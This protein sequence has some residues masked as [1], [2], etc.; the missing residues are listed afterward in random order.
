MSKIRK[1]FV[2]KNCSY[3]TSSWLGQC[4][5]CQEWNSFEENLISS[6][7]AS[8]SMT[9]KSR[10][11][12]NYELT[13]LSKTKSTKVDRISSNMPEVDRVLGGGFVPGQV[14]L[15][16]GEPGIGKS[17][18]LLEISKMLQ[19]NVLYV[20]AEESTQQ[21]K[22]RAERLGYKG[23][24][25]FVVQETNA[26]SV[27]D[28]IES[29]VEKDDIN[30]VIIDSIQ[31][32]S[33]DGLSG[34]AGSVGQLR[35][36]AQLFTQVA[37]RIHVPF[38]LVGHVTKEGEVAGPKVLEHIVDTVLILEGDTQNIF[39]ILKTSKNRFG[40]VSEV[41]VFEMKNEG[42][43]QVENPSQV[44]LENYKNRPGSCIT[45]TME[46]FRPILFEIQALTVKTSYGYPVRRTSGFSAN[47][48]QV[49]LAILERRCGVPV[50]SY[51]VYLNVVGGFNIS[52]YAADLAVC[53]SVA[54]SIKDIALKDGICAF[55]ECG[56]GGELRKIS[57]IEKRIKEAKKL[58]FSRVVSSDTVSSLPD[59]IKKSLSP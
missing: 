10:P 30:L 7:N 33:A 41:G 39:R 6:T 44:F 3:E 40:A 54:S 14:I 34:M 36:C 18:I 27:C 32:F 35:N 58:G 17:T 47:R 49:L 25:M 56:L 37:K 43:V 55:G 38:V 8:G 22:I 19:K 2:C 26:Q 52:E 29:N 50:S 13:P 15:I 11:N 45:V 46:G 48:L 57:H 4:P 5:K 12:L 53:L 9:V 24:N 16:A 59:A 1:V 21:I 23:E 42:M 31:M 28:L 20:A 51:D